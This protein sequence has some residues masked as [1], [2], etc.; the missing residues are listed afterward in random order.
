MMGKGFEVR[1]ETLPTLQR[2]LVSQYFYDQLF[3]HNKLTILFIQ[4]L[5]LK[6]PFD[7]AY[8]IDL[9]RDFA[10]FIMVKKCFSL[11]KP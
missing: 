6:I 7:V 9:E 11:L 8:I 2:F 4:P 1:L 5:E 3:E 10:S